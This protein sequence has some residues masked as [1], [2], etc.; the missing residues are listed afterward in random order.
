M[1]GYV[2]GF[3]CCLPNISA[4]NGRFR[5]VYVVVFKKYVQ[6]MYFT[7]GSPDHQNFHTNE[8]KQFRIMITV[9]VLFLKQ[10]KS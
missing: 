8:N 6:S 4:E 5:Y 10:P 3:T 2:S 1:C 9:L 7:L